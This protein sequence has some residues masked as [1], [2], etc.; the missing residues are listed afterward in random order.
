MLVAILGLAA[1]QVASA[2]EPADAGVEPPEAAASTPALD[3]DGRDQDAESPVAP[4]SPPP[5][6]PDAATVP[7]PT[8]AAETPAAPAAERPPRGA[9]LRLK[10]L[11]RDLARVR[12]QPS[13]MVRSIL[14]MGVGAGL[15]GLGF[16]VEPQL[17]YDEVMHGAASL[18]FACGASLVVYGALDLWLSPAPRRQILEY[19]LLPHRTPAE[20]RYRVRAG[21]DILR[22]TAEATARSRIVLGIH[23]MAAAGAM[24]AVYELRI[25]GTE[26]EIFSGVTIL[27]GAI[28][29]AIGVAEVLVTS[30]VEDRWNAY[31]SLR[32]QLRRPA[33]DEPREVAA[34][35]GS[36]ET[37]R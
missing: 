2:Q 33:T 35:V 13:P 18:L 34:A 25:Q 14:R 19:R 23:R 4:E 15:F 24:V 17:G 10:A 29:F 12:R 30:D 26:S 20:I 37:A 32:R 28:A 1:C 36:P 16:A 7:P 31:R 8:E 6:Q 11:N 27:A 22:T 3:G 5:E 9:E 21:E